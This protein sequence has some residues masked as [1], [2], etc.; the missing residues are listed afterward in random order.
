MSCNLYIQGEPNRDKEGREKEF[1]TAK[2][3]GLVNRK[4]RCENC[5]SFKD[6]ICMLYQTLNESNGEIFNLD[7]KV[8]PQGC[9]N[10]QMPK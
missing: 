2:Q 8:N 5:R 3:A 7:E 6:G 9:C 4:V 1:L 10:A